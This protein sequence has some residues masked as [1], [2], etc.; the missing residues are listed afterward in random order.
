MK[1]MI[2]FQLFIA[3]SFFLWLSCAVNPVTGKRELMLLSRSD[4]IALGQQ[5][6][7]EIVEMYGLYDDESL[8]NYIQGLGRRMTPVTHQPS[9]PYSFKVLDTDV[10]NAF[11]V[12]GGFV[13]FTRG[14]L[15]Y[16][17]NEAELAGVM[18]H[19]L[20]HINA[21][22][23]AK[24]ISKAQLAQFGLEL[25]S[26]VSETFAKLSGL[27]G[28]GVQMLFLKFSRDNE[29]EADNLGVEYASK[30]GYDAK[31]MATFFQT[32]ER[33]HPSDESGLPDW[34]STHPDPVNRIDAVSQKTR[35]WQERLA[36]KKFVFN[37][38]SYIMHIDGLIF[39]PDPKQGYVE[40][41][42]FYHPAFTFQFPV[43]AQWQV[44]NMASQV[45]MV[46]PQQNGIL[47]FTLVKAST[48]ND[49]AGN[50]IQNTQARVLQQNSKTIHGF[51]A[52]EIFSEISGN[53]S[54]KLI[55]TFIRKDEHIFAFHGYSAP[56]D[57]EDQFLSVFQNSMAEYKR[58]TDSKRIN[59]MP[60]RIY[61]KTVE[62]S[63]SLSQYLRKQKIDPENYGNIEIINGFTM[64]TALKEGDKIKI[65]E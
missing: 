54:L 35:E 21:R 63:E 51:S 12:P 57:F 7:K 47:L 23:S 49:A 43:P 59:V 64:N 17:N 38:N 14:I 42:I 27:A 28:L 55:S 53:Q 56:S 46:S 37:R 29:R 1:T 52:L 39:G 41:N 18:G 50:F 4:E 32:L 2:R 34:F 58:L 33:M 31:G 13:Y 16:L 9:L 45:Q 25:G 20:G 30:T 15:A 22:H 11:A 19:E 48:L 5:T 36:G 26:A 60:K 62:E 65:I 6:D 8:Q 40:D 10:V 3:V 44:S 61:I 24:I